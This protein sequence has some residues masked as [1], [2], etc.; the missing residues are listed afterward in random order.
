MIAIN[1]SILGELPSG[2]GQYALNVIRALD[3]LVLPSR[4]MAVWAEQF[5]HV[6]IEAM[7]AGVPVI[8]SSSG[9][10]PEVIGDAGL[11]FPE[12]DVGS[13]RRQLSWLLGDEA[14]RKTLVHRG[15]ERVRTRYTHA[16][17]ARAQRDIYVR[18]LAG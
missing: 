1:A 4:T 5:G 3:A 6:L 7:A 12:D 14:L 17:I 8:G 9:A 18:L 10:I 2:L 11:I 15:H 13:L 16:V